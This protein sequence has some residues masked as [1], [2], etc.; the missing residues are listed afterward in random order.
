MEKLLGVRRHKAEQTLD[1]ASRW[2]VMEADG[3]EQDENRDAQRQRYQRH[4]WES[5]PEDGRVC[6]VHLPVQV[7]TDQVCRNRLFQLHLNTRKISHRSSSNLKRFRNRLTLGS[8]RSSL[9]PSISRLQR[10]SRRLRSR[11]DQRLRFETW[12]AGSLISMIGS[13]ELPWP[14]GERGRRRRSARSARPLY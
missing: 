6:F 12:V 13:G 2:D 3:L 1:D 14:N 5:V 4:Y 7:Q 9:T 10:N 8:C 11:V